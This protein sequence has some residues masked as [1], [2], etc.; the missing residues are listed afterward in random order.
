MCVGFNVAFCVFAEGVGKYYNC[1]GFGQGCPFVEDG[2]AWKSAGG[3]VVG[4]M[5]CDINICHLAN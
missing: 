1:F 3:M 4:H 2:A 5:F